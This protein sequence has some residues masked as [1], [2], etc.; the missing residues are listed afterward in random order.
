MSSQTAPL[1]RGSATQSAAA[2][3]ATAT[4]TK[5]ATAAV[6]RLILGVEAQ[7]D[8][9]VAAIRTLTLNVAGSE[10]KNWE[11]DFTNGPFLFMFPVALKT[12]INEAVTLVLEASGSGGTSG[13]CTVWVADD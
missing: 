9:G 7:Y 4:A 12:E 1:L 2:D 5:A 6:K 13:D 3:N 11:W 8:I 10:V